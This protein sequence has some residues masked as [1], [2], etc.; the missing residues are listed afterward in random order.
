M[1]IAINPAFAKI[2]K[3]ALP[4]AAVGGAAAFL[5][6]CGTPNEGRTGDGI[7]RDLF[8]SYDKGQ[9]GSS[10]AANDGFLE[11]GKETFRGYRGTD[12][13]CESGYYYDS[14]GDGYSTDFHCSVTRHDHYLYTYSADKI[15]RDA[16]AYTGKDANG[17]AIGNNDGFA[18]DAEVAAMIMHKYDVGYTNKEGNLVGAA[19][20]KLESQEAEKFNDAYSS[21]AEDYVGREFEG[22]TYSYSLSNGEHKKAGSV[23]DAIA[24][25]QKLAPEGAEFVAPKAADAMAMEE[26]PEGESGPNGAEKVIGE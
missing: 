20:G 7:A 8:K 2:A 4:I 24:A 14:D 6:S 26:L 1:S 23:Q 21:D 12:S 5:A 15:G 19:N 10:S 11:L 22:S 13:T 3:F 18:H 16:D 17:E 25:A 9:N